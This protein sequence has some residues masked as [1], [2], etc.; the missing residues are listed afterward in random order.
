MPELVDFMLDFALLYSLR[1]QSLPA[2]WD[3]SWQP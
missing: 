3:P 2:A 1:S